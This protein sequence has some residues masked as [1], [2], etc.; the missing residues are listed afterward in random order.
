[1]KIEAESRTR[2]VTYLVVVKKDLVAR[3]LGATAAPLPKA[4]YVKLVFAFCNPVSCVEAGG[5]SLAVAM[6]MSMRIVLGK[7]RIRSPKPK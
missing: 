4:R 7:N 1:M 5:G 2:K 6:M 3:L